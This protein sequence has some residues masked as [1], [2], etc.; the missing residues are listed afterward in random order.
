[1]KTYVNQM[2][3]ILGLCSLVAAC[4]EHAARQAGQ[5]AAMG[6]ASGAVGGMVSALIFGGDPVEAAARGAVYAGA[7]SATVGAISGSQKDASIE[8]QR[9]ARED[10]IRDKIGSDAFKGLSALATCDHEDTLTYAAASKTSSNP[11]F[12]VAG[13]WLELLSLAD[14]NDT[15]AVDQRINGVVEQDWDTNSEQQARN[16]L[17][18][19]QYQL[20]QLR[21]EYKLPKQCT[22]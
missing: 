12:V 4:G 17:D 9:K 19:L 20:E 5:G 14:S 16:Q 6:A 22:G 13:Y 18:Q 8:A 1:M 21:L 2:V 11:N 3:V 15:I 7:A 10:Q